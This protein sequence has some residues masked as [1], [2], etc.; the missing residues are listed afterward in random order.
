MTKLKLIDHFGSLPFKRPSSLPSGNKKKINI[1][2]KSKKKNCE[3]I[4]HKGIQ[5]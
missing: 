2:I 4:T 5:Q 3:K 1:S